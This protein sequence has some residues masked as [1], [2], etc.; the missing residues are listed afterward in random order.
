[1]NFL[2]QQIFCITLNLNFV[3]LEIFVNLQDGKFSSAII[4]ESTLTFDTIVWIFNYNPILLPALSPTMTLHMGHWP[5]TGHMSSG[6]TGVPV[7]T[8]ATLH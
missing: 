3:I 1:M 5:Y 7:I 4:Y 6:Y 2:F 8:L